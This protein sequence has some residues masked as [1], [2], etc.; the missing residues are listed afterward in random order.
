MGHYVPLPSP[1][2]D[3]HAHSD[4]V[5]HSE[6]CGNRQFNVREPSDTTHADSHWDGYHPGYKT[7]ADYA[8][9]TSETELSYCQSDE[10]VA[11]VCDHPWNRRYPESAGRRDCAS[12]MPAN[13]NS[14]PDARSGWNKGCIV[15]VTFAVPDVVT[16]G[17]DPSPELATS[18]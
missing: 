1:R 3:S 14:K 11:S 2:G 12:D 6:D 17:A 9:R 16:Y 4:Q 8:K 18:P 13:L 10:A 7:A 5:E 15:G